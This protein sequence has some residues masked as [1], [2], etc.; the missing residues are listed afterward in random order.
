M[1]T[2]FNTTVKIYSGVPLVKGGTEV[3]YLSQGA[4]EGVLG[5]YLKKTYSNYYYT[6]ENENYIQVDDPIQN[7]EGCNYVSF[8]N[9]SHGGKIYF[10][11]ID[12]LEYVNDNCTGIVFTVDPW[13]TYLGD[14]KTILTPYIIRNT[15]D[16]DTDYA[17]N[18]ED[19]DFYGQGP[20]YDTVSHNAISL[21]SMLVLFT[22]D[23]S[24]TGNGLV[25]NG[26][27][28]G[29]QY[30]VNPSVTQIQ[31]V[32]EAGGNILG[33]YAVPSGWAAGVTPASIDITPAI[34]Y[35]GTHAKL[36]GGQYNK[37]SVVTSAGAKEF[38][39]MKF[40]NKT[41]QFRIKF[42]FMPAPN[43]VI[44]PLNYE[45]VSEN[46]AEGITIA[47]PSVP[48]SYKD[49][50]SI[51][52]A[53]SN[54]ASIFK[55]RMDAA[56]AEILPTTNDEGKTGTYRTDPFTG[57]QVYMP[58]PFSNI[59][60]QVRSWQHN[61][62]ARQN[63]ILNM[64]GIPKNVRKAAMASA[65]INTAA[66]NIVLNNANQIVIDVVHAHHTASDL[67]LLDQYF[68]YYG[69]SI[70]SYGTINTLDKSYLQVGQEIYF[71]SEAD[72]ILNAMAIS[73]IKIRRT[74]Q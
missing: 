6:R 39:L 63:A 55:A 40:T 27:S 20:V 48:M 29:I 25:V 57:A 72:D 53:I 24:F 61:A 26:F 23:T 15:Q 7:L 41:V 52:G 44:Y 68:D 21:G 32:V 60:N 73:G 42:L 38:D 16:P 64:K 35:G 22:C 49:D 3:L 1:A 56:D 62:Q 43:A 37:I 67:A 10:G 9:L 65:G 31:Q 66:G 18:E 30:F 54:M 34:T 12:H 51:S 47:V 45:G 17:N 74:L 13:P 19:F 4:A 5:A 69:Y 50:F 2:T 33:A 8:T 46:T 58:N 71:G 36:K 59:K 28:T 11:F 70:N 14:C